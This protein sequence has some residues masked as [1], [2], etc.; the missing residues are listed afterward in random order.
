[1]K[2]TEL[3]YIGSELELFQHAKNWK[4]YFASKIVNFLGESV[5]EVGA[6]NGSSTEIFTD[7][8]IKQW[9][10]LE[11]DPDLAALIGNRISEDPKFKNV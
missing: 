2:S 1:M 4:R 6:G 10:C 8:G 11:P 9:L 7:L 3:S 5:L